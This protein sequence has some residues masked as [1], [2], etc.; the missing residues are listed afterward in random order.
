MRMP[1][2][3]PVELQASLSRMVGHHGDDHDP[4]LIHCRFRPAPCFPTYVIGA[5]GEARRSISAALENLLEREFPASQGDWVLEAEEARLI[6]RS[7]PA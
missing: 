7:M 1:R 6:A 5:R 3:H 2:P 4:A